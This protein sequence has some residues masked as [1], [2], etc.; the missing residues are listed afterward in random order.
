MYKQIHIGKLI[1]DRMAE[2]GMEL[3]E[4]SKK[5]GSSVRITG[6]LLNN[7]DINCRLLLK[8]SKILEYDFF[9][10]YSMNLLFYAPPTMGFRKQLNPGTKPSLPRF[11]RNTYTP[12]VIGYIIGKFRSGEMTPA[13][14][15]EMYRI[16][17][18]T[19]YRWLKK[20]NTPSYEL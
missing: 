18:T 5:L 3:D 19:L 13:Q 17:K 15:L 1:T 20:Y 6:T 2:Q 8:I 7:E 16:P 11:A 12:Q 10:I 4:L 9:R 14:I